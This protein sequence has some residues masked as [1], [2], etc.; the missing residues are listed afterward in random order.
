MSDGR[1]FQ[2]L[3]VR[4]INEDWKWDVRLVDILTVKGWQERL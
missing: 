2:S 1:E 3:D 4:G